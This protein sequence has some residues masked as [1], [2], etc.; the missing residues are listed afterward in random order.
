MPPTGT[1]NEPDRFGCSLRT[2]GF[3]LRT[4]KLSFF[5]EEEEDTGPEL[6][7]VPSFSLERGAEIA[8]READMGLVA[9]LVGSWT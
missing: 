9:A 4:D 5:S 7:V 2:G 8:L 3:F 1:G 6:L